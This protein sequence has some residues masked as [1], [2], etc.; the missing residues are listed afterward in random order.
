MINLNILLRNLK[1]DLTKKIPPHINL[2]IEESIEDLRHQQ[3][4]KSSPQKG[5]TLLP[6]SIPNIEGKDVCLDSLLQNNEYVVISFYR[7]TWCPYCNL[8][9]KTFQKI[10]PQ[11]QQKKATL[12]AISPQCYQKSKTVLDQNPFDF[13]ICIDNNNLYAK[14]IGIAFELQTFIQ[15]YYMQL[16]INLSEHNLNTDFS[17]PVPAVFVVDKNKTIVYSFIDVD[18]SKRVDIDELLNILQ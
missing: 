5:D 10:R 1:S 14:S 16:G 7:G 9:L 3:I 8:E 4:V 11:L 15:P 18:Y 12:V 2:K 17:L 13:D 6:F